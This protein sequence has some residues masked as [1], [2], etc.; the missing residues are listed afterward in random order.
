MITFDGRAGGG[1]LLGYGIRGDLVV[2]RSRTWPD[3][4]DDL[5][6]RCC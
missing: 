3:A 4:S 2:M 6:S 1:E 5:R